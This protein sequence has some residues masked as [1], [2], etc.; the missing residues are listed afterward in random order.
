MTYQVSRRTTQSDVRR[1]DFYQTSTTVIASYYIKKIDKERAHIA[2]PSSTSVL[3]DLPTADNKRY[4]T[5]LPL[6][7]QIDPVRS[8]SKIMGTKVELKLEKVDGAGWPVLRS[9]ENRGSDII[10]VG[11]AGRA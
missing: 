11:Q 10:Q 1:H 2:F 7:G 8:T 3:L 5:E 4:R 9:D 6:F